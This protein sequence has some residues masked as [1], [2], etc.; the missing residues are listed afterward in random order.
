MHV[1]DVDLTADDLIADLE[2]ELPRTGGTL[3]RAN[4]GGLVKLAVVVVP[5]A[6]AIDRFGSRLIAVGVAIAFVVL[7]WF[8]Y[9]QRPLSEPDSYV[10]GWIGGA[11]AVV[12]LL[13][14]G[15][16]AG[17]PGLPVPPEAPCALGGA[18]ATLG[19]LHARAV[20]PLRWYAAVLM[21]LGTAAVLLPIVLKAALIVV[22]LAVLY[23]LLASL[24]DSF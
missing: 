2:L 22:G 19:V 1:G 10:L 23:V 20:Q 14:G 8:A 11:L 16:L 13:L 3:E 7:L 18:A 12:A 4:T 6:S 15:M 21:F 5:R 24:L 17:D 9:F